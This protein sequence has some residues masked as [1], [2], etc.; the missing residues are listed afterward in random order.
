MITM[1]HEI[2]CLDITPIHDTSIAELC[3][4]G[5]WTD[6]TVRLLSLPSLELVKTEYL[7]GDYIAR[8]IL[9]TSL[10]H[11]RYLLCGLGNLV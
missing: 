6:I 9:L 5:L 7:G 8:S 4:V 11:Q 3:A 1:D 2:S 10:E